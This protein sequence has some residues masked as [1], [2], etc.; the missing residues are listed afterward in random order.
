MKAPC[1]PILE[2]LGHVIVNGDPRKHKKT[3][4]F[5]LKIYL[6]AY[7][8]KTTRRAKLKFKCNV[9][10]YKCFMQT[11]FGGTWAHMTE[12]SSFGLINE[13]F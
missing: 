1:I 12:I 9:G 7:N 11:E 6:F 2:I 5:Y 4:F 10:A 3:A 13:F 8:S